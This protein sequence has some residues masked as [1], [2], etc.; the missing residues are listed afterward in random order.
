M[1]GRRRQVEVAR[2]RG[3]REREG[4]VSHRLPR[5]APPDPDDHAPPHPIGKGERAH[6][7]ELALLHT[8][9]DEPVHERALRVQEVELAVEAAPGRRDGRRVGQHAERARH[10]GEVAPG[11]LAG[12]SLQMPSLKP[13]G[14]QSTNWIV[15]LVLMA[16]TAELT[17]LGTTSP[18]YRSAHAMYLPWRG[19]HLT[20]WLFGSKHEW[21]SSETELASCDALD[22]EMMGA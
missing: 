20:I 16:A 18:R 2:G 17:S 9:A 7:G 5:H 10:L 3:K 6:L 13:V 21:V 19:S 15:R 14:H 12:G 11:T 4:Y 1:V 8:L 22:A